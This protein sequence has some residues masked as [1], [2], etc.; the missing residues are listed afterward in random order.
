M[1]PFMCALCF[2]SGS[3]LMNP[4]S[5]TVNVQPQPPLIDLVLVM[6]AEKGS[7][8]RINMTIFD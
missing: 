7:R 5:Q 4:E 8:E 3:S 1:R 6:I 2:F